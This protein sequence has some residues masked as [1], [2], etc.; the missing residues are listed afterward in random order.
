MWGPSG[1]G[2]MVVGDGFRVRVCGRVQAVAL[3]AGA[4]H[5]LEGPYLCGA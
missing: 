5:H 2:E 4:N 1:G 3:W